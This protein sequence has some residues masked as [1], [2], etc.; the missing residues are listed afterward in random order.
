MKRKEFLT[1]LFVGVMA[2]FGTQAF[3][4][5]SV[6]ITEKEIKVRIIKILKANDTLKIDW[7]QFR[8]DWSFVKDLGMDSL[9]TVEFIM[10]IEKE[11]SISIPDPIAE[12]MTRLQQAVNYLIKVLN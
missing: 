2:P 5:Q 4:N 6:K 10:S 11:F 12:K 8:W 3:A 7:K 9:D 1:A